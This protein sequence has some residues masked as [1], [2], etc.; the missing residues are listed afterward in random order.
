[1]YWSDSYGLVELNI[2]K[3]QAHIGYHQGQCDNDIKGLRDVPSIKR[4]LDQLKPEI[5]SLVLKDYG[6]WDVN[7]L[8][9]HDDNLDRL[10]WIACGDIV[11]N[12]V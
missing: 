8:S 1:M 11:E 10:L 2:T 12:N 5:V 3:K 9:D 6:A 4:Q 7:D